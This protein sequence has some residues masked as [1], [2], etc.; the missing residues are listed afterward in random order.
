VIA[1]GAGCSYRRTLEEWLARSN[2]SSTV[3]GILL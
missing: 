2:R 1:F 3:S